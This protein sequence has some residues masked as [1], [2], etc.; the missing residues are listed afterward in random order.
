MEEVEK[1]RKQLGEGRGGGRRHIAQIF[2]KK[3]NIKE[4]FTTKYLMIK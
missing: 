3:D 1:K 2:L 4:C